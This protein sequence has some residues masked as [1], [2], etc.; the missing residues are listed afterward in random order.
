MHP[1]K[2]SF[3]PP[4]CLALGY[5]LFISGLIYFGHFH[6]HSVRCYF[7]NIKLCSSYHLLQVTESQVCIFYRSALKHLKTERVKKFDYCM[8]CKLDW[9]FFVFVDPYCASPGVYVTFFCF[10]ILWIPLPIEGICPAK[11][12]VN[13]TI[14]NRSKCSVGL[15]LHISWMLWSNSTSW[16]DCPFANQNFMSLKCAVE[17]TC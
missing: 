1:A 6:L 5:I 7:S 4:K 12:L 13:H 9:V 8:P 10:R 14:Q 15:R 17:L 11:D 3:M 2:V 16:N